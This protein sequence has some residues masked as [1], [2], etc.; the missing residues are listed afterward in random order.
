MKRAEKILSK[1]KE[2]SKLDENV[3]KA[4][5]YIQKELSKIAADVKKK[6]GISKTYVSSEKANN[7]DKSGDWN[8]A[9]KVFIEIGMDE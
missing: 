3:S 7:V 4:N 1:I 6:F 9:M 8:K 5:T 2:E